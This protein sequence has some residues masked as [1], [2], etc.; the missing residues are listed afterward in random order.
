MIELQ[1]RRIL[2]T[3]ATGFIGSALVRALSGR[4]ARVRCLDNNS[5]GTR[6]KLGTAIGQVE[7][8]I[9][10]IRDLETVRRAVRGMDT[11]CHLAYVN[12]T[13]FFYQKP[14]LVLEVAVKGM[15]NVVD[16]CLAESVGDLVVASSSEVYQD[17]ERIPTP[18]DVPLTVPDV[19]NPRYSYGGGK[20][21]TELL[22][23]NYGRERF[24]R[25]TI[26]R[27]HNVYGPDMGQ[28]HVSPQF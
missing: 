10:D 24:K 2:V 25:A 16:A 5:R 17:A 19:C 12:G 6:D 18:E 3:G 23:M 7:L 13:E 28:V 15:M 27:S 21:I 1:G 8:V 4:G 20:I 9:G 11:V 26:F 22:P 14:A